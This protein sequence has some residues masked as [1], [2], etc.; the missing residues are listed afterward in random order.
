MYLGP[1]GD[2]GFS[3]YPGLTGDTG[4]P[5]FPGP[6]GPPGAPAF[7][8]GTIDIHFNGLWLKSYSLLRRMYYDFSKWSDLIFL[9]LGQKNDKNNSIELH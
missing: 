8:T 9:S 1:Q 7:I 6:P 4:F 2:P 5:G 3:G